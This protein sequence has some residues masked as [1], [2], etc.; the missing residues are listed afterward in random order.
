LAARYQ[1]NDTL[2]LYAHLENLLNEEYELANGYNTPRQGLYGGM[3][4]DF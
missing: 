3:R 4:I 2:T 1:A